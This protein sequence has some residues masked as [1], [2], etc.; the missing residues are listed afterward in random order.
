M[1]IEQQSTPADVWRFFDSPAKMKDITWAPKRQ[2]SKSLF[3]S[4][5]RRHNMKPRRLCFSDAFEDDG[6]DEILAK[7]LDYTTDEFAALDLNDNDVK[8][9]PVTSRN[10]SMTEPTPSE[11]DQQM[12]R[13]QR[14]GPKIKGRSLKF[15]P[16]EDCRIVRASRRIKLDG[17]VEQKLK[18]MC[19]NVR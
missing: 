10:R 17:V 12:E 13:F 9:T 4:S 8:S 3:A 18:S 6:T 16:E 14:R 1:E 7:P 5:Q 11:L 15:T 2:R 19:K